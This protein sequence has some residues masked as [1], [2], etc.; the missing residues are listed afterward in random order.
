MYHIFFIHSSVDGHLGCF[1]VLAIVNSAV[2]NTGVYTSFWIMIFS[3][4][5]P[6]SGIVGSHGSTSFS[7][8]RNFHTVFHSI[9]WNLHSHQQHK[10]V[11]ANNFRSSL[12]PELKQLWVF[13]LQTPELTISHDLF[14]PRE[15]GESGRETRLFALFPGPRISY[16]KRERIYFIMF[17][18]LSLDDVFHHIQKIGTCYYVAQRLKRLLPMRETRVWSLGWEDPLENEMAT[19]SSILAWRIPWMEESGGLWS[20]GSQRVGHDWATWL[21][22]SLPH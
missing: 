21:S 7:F 4:Y 15:W 1:H 22:L 14:K 13:F 12:K 6:S 9:P 17:F 3:G 2:M 10:G 8:Q 20:T 18:E 19:H 5:M 16:I 11:S